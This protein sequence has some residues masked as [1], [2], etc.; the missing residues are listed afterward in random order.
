MIALLVATATQG[1]TPDPTSVASNKLF[2]IV[3]NIADRRE[4]NY[5]RHIDNCYSGIHT[6]NSLAPAGAPLR[7][8]SDDDSPDEVCLAVHNQKSVCPVDQTRKS[9]GSSHTQLDLVVLSVELSCPE[10]VSH[11]RWISPRTPLVYTLCRMTC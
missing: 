11:C 2:D 8:S 10:S 9:C 3:G 4:S 7:D 5:F 1:L 6:Q